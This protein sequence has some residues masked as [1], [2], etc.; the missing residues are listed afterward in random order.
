[1]SL[2]SL[3]F[4]TKS[5]IGQIAFDALI[6]ENVTTDAMITTNPVESGAD[7]VD[8]IVLMPLTFKVE[9]VISDTPVSLLGNITNIFNDER[10][11]V[12]AWNALLKLQSEKKP[13]TY[14]NNLKKYDNIAIKSLSYTQDKSSS[15]ILHFTATL[16]EVITVASKKIK[17]EQ[18]ND[19]KVSDLAL[20]TV[21]RGQL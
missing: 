8:N 10:E 13:F 21:N 7:V 19:S 6:S 9:G 18:F 16:Q 12:K 17:K 14:V 3:F 1:M 5:G 20:P 2:A 15:N 11:T 4:Q